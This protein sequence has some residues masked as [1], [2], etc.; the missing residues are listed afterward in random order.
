MQAGRQRRDPGYGDRLVRWRGAEEALCSLV[1]ADVERYQ[2]AMVLVG[3]ALTELRR[4][5]RDAAGLLA[6]TERPE[7]ARVLGAGGVEEALA[8]QLDPATVLYAACAQ[9][10]VELE[11]RGG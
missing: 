10:A 2:R 7:P 11:Q 5:C 3:Q 1:F 8:C 9:R 4:D 6:M